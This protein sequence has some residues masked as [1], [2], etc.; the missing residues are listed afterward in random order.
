MGRI[1][2]A[3]LQD[4]T[5]TNTQIATNAAIAFSKLASLTSGN[6]LVGNASN[7]PT[8]VAMSGDVTISNAGVAAIGAGVVVNADV[9]AS[10]AIA[11]SKLAFA[12]SGGHSHDGADS[13]L[14][15]A[16]TKIWDE[17]PTGTVNDSNT[18]YTLASAPSAQQLMVF[19]NG[20]KLQRVATAAAQ[21]EYEHVSGASVF[22][23]GSPP[24][25]SGDGDILEVH[26]QPA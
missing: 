23:L 1:R 10:A 21:D 20:V 11:E 6:L 16:V 7:V 14:I 18:L 19:L 8:S 15:A 24:R 17:T 2:G 13:T 3:Q 9:N 12:T 5:L 25:T 22:T 26:Y 4:A